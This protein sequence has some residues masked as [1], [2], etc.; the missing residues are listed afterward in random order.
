MD[1]IYAG[2]A[3]ALQAADYV[4]S[5]RRVFAPEVSGYS[6][7]CAVR[8]IGQSLPDRTGPSAFTSLFL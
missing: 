1:L 7:L 3:D 2:D 6:M 4:S 8:S 5:V